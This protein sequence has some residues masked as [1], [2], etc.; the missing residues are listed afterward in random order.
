MTEAIE[1]TPE[2]YMASL[3]KECD[4]LKGLLAEARAH[5]CELVFLLA[6]IV[7][8]KFEGK[9]EMTLLEV[10]NTKNFFDIEHHINSSD[11][12]IDQ[13]DTH[14]ITTKRKPTEPTET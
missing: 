12:A 9:L 1:M 4:N 13:D 2:Q 8:Y 3:E 14:V 5:R 6:A 7:R 11:I 10:D